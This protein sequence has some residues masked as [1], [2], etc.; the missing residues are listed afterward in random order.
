MASCVVLYKMTAC[1]CGGRE[2]LGGSC[3]GTPLR[4]Q[5]LRQT[6]F[7]GEKG[8]RGKKRRK[9]KERF[10]EVKWLLL[11]NLGR[12]CKPPGDELLLGSIKSNKIFPRVG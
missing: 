6:K 2:D 12:A 11:G 1:W 3:R 8:G 7:I 5:D 10:L 9:E 4:N